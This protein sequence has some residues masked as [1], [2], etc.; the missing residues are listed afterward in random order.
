[1]PSAR[2]EGLLSLFRSRP[3]LALE[4]LAVLGPA[5]TARGPVA[6]LEAG[7]VELPPVE[8][9][10]DLV[11]S[12]GQPRPE[13]VVVVEVQLRRDRA[14]PRRWMLYAAA[15]ADRHGC[16]VE[17]LVVTPAQGVARWASAPVELS[18]G[19]AWAPRVAGPESL[20]R[21]D[22]EAAQRA[23]ELAVLAAIAHA[24]APDAAAAVIGAMEAIAATR[25]IPPDQRAMYH[26][27][28]LAALPEAAE[29]ELRAMVA[30]GK[31][32]WQSRFAREHIAQGR[33]EG[34][35]EGRREVLAVR[36][37]R[38]GLTL[39]DEARAGLESAGA[40]QLDAWI[41]ALMDGEPAERVLEAIRR[42]V[43]S[44][45]PDP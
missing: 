12:V 2:H 15:L 28:M 42:A 39:D 31:Y 6:V 32:E 22:A 33:E 45:R 29:R 7:A 44:S 14:K 10:A 23:P 18:P 25:R 16:A 11:V 26:D 1:M 35:E 41:L 36:F 34:R 8:R 37:A 13:L 3:E 30:Q 20:P 40:E 38:Q 9:R 27:L 4:L 24:G 21:L 17:V 19:Q 43:G 5:P